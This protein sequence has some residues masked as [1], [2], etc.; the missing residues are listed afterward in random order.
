MSTLFVDDLLGVVPR[1][2][3]ILPTDRL[4]DTARLVYNRMHDERPVAI[5]RSL[6]PQVLTKSIAVAA[7]HGVELAVRGGGHH[8]GGF[9]T[10]DDGLLIDFSE[11]RGVRYDSK[12]ETAIVEPGARLANLDEVLATYKRCVPAG[13]VSDTGVAGL[14]LGGGIGWLVCGYGLTCDYLR[15]ATLLTG[16]GRLLEVSPTAHAELFSALRGGGVGAFGLVLELRFATIQLPTIVA[17][18]VRFPVGETARVLS[19]LQQMQAEA[20][21]KATSVAPTLIHDRGTAVLSL[22][23]CC[24]DSAAAELDR[25]AVAV[26]GN[27][28]DIVERPYTQWQKQFDDQFDPPRRGYWKSVH[29]DSNTLDGDL[30]RS[31]IENSPSDGCTV[32][33]EVYNPETLAAYAGGSTYPLRNSQI[34]VLLAARWDDPRDDERHTSWARTWAA[35]L[36]S[37]GG[38]KGYSNYSALDDSSPRSA[39]DAH[40]LHLFDS[41]ERNYDPSGRYRR[42][43]RSA[44]A[45]HRSSS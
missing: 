31:V 26:G 41:L 17:G 23:L 43:H 20:P 18:S 24:C 22:D 1:D 8:I 13:T 16:D 36:R 6:D 11:F 2:S 39:Y 38:G 9:S 34:G 30:V 14:T 29:F 27:W 4:Y 15:A 3:L 5:V 45:K 33:I 10:I 42:G 44:L 12:T 28:A 25:L 32:L 7:N 19:A 35:A 40:A 37:S 21:L